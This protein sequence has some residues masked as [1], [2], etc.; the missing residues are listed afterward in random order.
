MQCVPKYIS[1]A[2]HANDGVT[3]QA[4]LVK[5]SEVCANAGR[6]C[7]GAPGLYSGPAVCCD[8]ALSCQKLNYYY[9]RCMSAADAQAARA[10][11]GANLAAQQ[12]VV[13]GWQAARTPPPPAQQ[14]QNSNNKG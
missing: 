3:D 7:G 14:Q 8:S 10:S 4:L 11:F 5:P 1:T 9:S 6:Q 13:A 12:S 2:D